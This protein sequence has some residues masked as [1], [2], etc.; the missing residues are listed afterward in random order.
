MS[1]QLDNRNR[2]IIA[3]DFPDEQQA[4]ALV[5]RLDPAKCRVKVGKELFTR[6]GPVLVEKLV[7]SGFDVFLDLKFHDIPQTVAR[8]CVAAAELGVWMINVHALGGRKMMEAAHE[9]IQKSVHSP[10]L[11]AVTILTSMD[12]EDIHEI[13]LSGQATSNALHLAKLAQQSGLDG[14]VCSP[15]EVEAIRRSFGQEFLLV[16]PGIRPQ[17]SRQ[18]DQKRIMTPFEAVRL[19]ADYLVIGRPITAAADPDAAFQALQDEVE[20]ALTA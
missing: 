10:L 4:M 11:I 15:H 13:G 19:G 5:K 20:N 3:L 1:V 16:T 17:S 12:D 18:D 7:N 9:A 14:V 8:A 2:I 6:C